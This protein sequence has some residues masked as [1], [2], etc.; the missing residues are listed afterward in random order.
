MV[1]KGPPGTAVAGLPRFR[2][3]LRPLELS[4]GPFGRRLMLH[5]RLENLMPN[6]PIRSLPP[7]GSTDWGARQFYRLLDDEERIAAE[8]ER[9][10]AMGR[11]APQS[12]SRP[13]AQTSSLDQLSQGARS[14]AYTGIGP[15]RGPSATAPSSPAI[16]QVNETSEGFDWYGLYCALDPQSCII[17]QIFR[18]DGLGGSCPQPDCDEVRLDCKNLCTDMYAENPNSLPGVGPDMASRWRRCVRECMHAYGCFDF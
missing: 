2:P 18:R 5:V 12:N 1:P 13:Q 7:R 11:R 4:R 16:R 15:R 8:R 17:G 10:L 14:N 9:L 3:T 6:P